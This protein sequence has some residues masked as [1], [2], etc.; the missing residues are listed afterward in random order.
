MNRINCTSKSVDNPIDFLIVGGGINGLS[1]AISLLEKSPHAKVTILERGLLPCGATS[2]NGGFGMWVGFTEV[3]Q[4]IEDF[5]LDKAIAINIKRKSGLDILMKRLNNDPSI[6]QKVG[7]F[8]I[9]L[10]EELHQLDQLDS[11]NKAFARELGITDLFQVR[12]DQIEALGFNPQ[13]AKALVYHDYKYRIHSGKV[14]VGLIELFQ[15]LGGRYLTGAPVVSRS[16]RPDGLV[17]VFVGNPDTKVVFRA[18]T[19]IYAVNAFHH[20]M[21]KTSLVEPLRG[22][23]MVTK[24]IKDLKLVSSVTLD[25]SY[26]Y[27]RVI[28][29]R[30]II[31]GGLLDYESDKTNEMRTTEAYREHLVQKL[32]EI[33]PSLEFEPD[34]FWAGVMGMH[35]N[36]D[37]Y[38]A[39]QIEKGVWNLFACNGYGMMLN[40]FVGRE[41]ADL[42]SQ[43]L[44]QK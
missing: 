34:Y 41:A 22:H 39:T 23:V 16:S 37:I 3:I 42:I 28:D 10:S 2:K 33:F 9:I 17:D 29:N 21:D 27:L 25:V 30:I 44:E 11:I 12:N 13:L 26:Y 43:K 31:G 18:K 35:K 32:H 5:G 6:F 19:V 8:D 1:V 20:L 40:S 24:P 14:V 15:K 7:A 36:R 4:D 38:S